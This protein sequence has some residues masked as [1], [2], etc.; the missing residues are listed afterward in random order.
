MAKETMMRC[1]KELLKELREMKISKRESYA[2]IVKRIIK[3][4]RK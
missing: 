2:E 4:E 1:P 3:K